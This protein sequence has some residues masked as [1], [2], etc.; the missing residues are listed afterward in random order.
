[1]LT[2]PVAAVL[3]TTDG[4][5]CWVKTEDAAERRSL[6]LGDSD[7]QFIVLEAGLEEGEEVVLDPLASI[8]EAQIL[9]LE[10]FDETEQ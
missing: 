8:E 7:D 4:D 5:F 1:V 6:E 3:Q 10:P 9:A 2:I